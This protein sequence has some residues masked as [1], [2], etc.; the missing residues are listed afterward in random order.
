M[1]LDIKESQE[2]CDWL[3]Q[4]GLALSECADLLMNL[5]CGDTFA[6]ALFKVFLKRKELLEERDEKFNSYDWVVAAN[7]LQLRE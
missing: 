2:L 3:L 1:I 5:G 4:R 7:K 6:M